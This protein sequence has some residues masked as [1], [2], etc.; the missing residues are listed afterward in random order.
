VGGTQASLLPLFLLTMVRPPGTGP[1]AGWLAAYLVSSVAAGAFAALAVIA[2]HGVLVLM[3]PL[4]SMA[5][6]VR[7]GLVLLLV[8]C[9]PLILN[10][11]GTARAFAA[12]AWWLRWA[13]PMWFVG[14]ERRLLGRTDGAALALQAVLF[15]VAAAVMTIATYAILYRRF[16]RAMPSPS[17]WSAWRAER[18]RTSRR[19]A[20]SS[21]RR[22]V[23]AFASV[24]L[25]RSMLH[26]GIVVTL[27]AAVAGLVANRLLG[28][29][30]DR[31][32]DHWLLFWSPLAMMCIAAPTV[33]LALSV[34][35]ELRANWVFR[36][37]EEADTRAAVIAAGVRTVFVLGVVLPVAVMM[38]VQWLVLGWRTLLLASLE[39]GVGWLLVEVLMRDWRRLPFTCSYVPGKGF[40]P[41]MFVKGVATFLLFTN[42][43]GG[44]LAASMRRRDVL[45]VVLLLVVVSA[46]G[47]LVRRRRMASRFAL[48]FED[49]VPSEINPLR[50]NPD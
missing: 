12:G 26:Q 5:A 36:M 10:L 24:T 40:V 33:R 31:P 2:V 46:L 41:H 48:M 38:P 27:S 47:L 15:A 37:T 9:V 30:S 49:D 50:L 42:V 14:M 6:A 29:L 23:A 3:T 1:L 18:P 13:P 7:S 19:N 43:G 32:G 35:I 17:G 4:A 25:R 8:L 21:V 28:G 45:P 11:P 16:D 20:P 22:A 34:P 39:L 44:V